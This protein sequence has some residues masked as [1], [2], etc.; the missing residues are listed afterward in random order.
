[1]PKA[2]PPVIY[3]EDMSEEKT[4]S[5]CLHRDKTSMESPCFTCSSPS[6]H[7]WQP[8]QGNISRIKTKFY[9]TAE[10]IRAG[11]YNPHELCPDCSLKIL[12]GYCSPTHT[13]C[14]QRPIIDD[15]R[16]QLVEKDKEIERLK[17]AMRYVLY[18]A[19]KHTDEDIASI[20]KN[21]L[22]DINL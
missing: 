21:I 13:D 10:E 1:M 18:K 4:C 5:N 12:S 9:P 14:P 7:H 11:D 8:E 20:A 22:K 3:E 17:I 19:E 16:R 2:C 6:I 15:L